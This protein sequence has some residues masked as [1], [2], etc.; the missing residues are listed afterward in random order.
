MAPRLNADSHTA[1]KE[2]PLTTAIT[3]LNLHDLLDRRSLAAMLDEGYVRQQVHPTEPL[4]ILNY[5]EKAAYDNVWNAVTLACRGLIWNTATGE[6]VARPFRKFFNHGQVGAP[7]LDLDAEVIVTDKQDGS[8]GILYPLPS[9]GHAI[10]TR[11]SFASEQAIHA[12]QVW[13]DRYA[14]R[15]T[16]P[17]GL[18]LLFEIVYPTNRIVCDYGD[19]DDLVLLGAVS[20]ATG[21]SCQPD[22]VLCGGWPG[23]VTE[24][25][26][27][28][29]L[30]EALAAES[31]PNAEGLVVHFVDADERLKVK[32]AE[33][34]RLHRL[35]TGVT[36][37]TVWEHMV[38]GNPLND[39]IEP[40]PD[41]FHDWVRN[42]AA[43]IL[44]RVEAEEYRL[45][46]VYREVLARMPA[47]WSANDRAGRKDFAMVA[48]AHPDKWALFNQ[49]DG[50]D[51]Y[52]ELLKRAKPEP[53]L[54]PSG[55]TYTEDN[56]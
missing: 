48:A 3:A 54:T 32:Y 28:T 41:E 5:T 46:E 19:L 22:P 27:Y 43:G 24:T 11:G 26:A 4:A 17:A 51:I 56:A 16:A 50:K 20:I 42:V 7:D 9:G 34:V 13:N 49:L 23:P 47:G 52:G 35:V 36:A 12:T 8:L 55:R 29:T 6:I 1:T 44:A 10:A 37:R 14:G 15:V 53:Y 40:L 31:R 18:T 45:G 21:E 33:Y 38:A 25:F 2:S 39:L 30:A